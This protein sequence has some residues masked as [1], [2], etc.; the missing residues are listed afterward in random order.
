MNGSLKIM[1]HDDKDNVKKIEV[2]LKEVMNDRA[3]RN[4]REWK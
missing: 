3:L 4:G 2:D 1:L